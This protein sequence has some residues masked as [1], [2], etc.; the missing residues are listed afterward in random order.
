MC[1]GLSSIGHEA[2]ED[3]DRVA[4]VGD[5][6]LVR[7]LEAELSMRPERPAVIVTSLT[8]EEAADVSE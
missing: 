8:V 5:E 1:V 4:V 3:R 2:S 6:C 7:E